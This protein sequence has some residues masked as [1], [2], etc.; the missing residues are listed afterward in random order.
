MSGT[1]TIEIPKIRIYGVGDLNRLMPFEFEGQV[2]AE[3]G[4][5]GKPLKDIHKGSIS[6]AEEATLF[7][8]YLL[9]ELDEYTPSEETRGVIK[10]LFER[11]GRGNVTDDAC[12]YDNGDKRMKKARPTDRRVRWIPHPEGFEKAD[13]V[14]K[15]II[16]ED[17]FKDILVPETGYVEMTCDGLYRPDTGTPFSTAKSRERA[18]KSLTDRGF[19]PDF[20]RKA[21]SYFYSRN[22]GE[23]TAAVVRWFGSA[24]GGRF[25]VFTDYVPDGRSPSVGSFPASRSAERSEA[26][27]EKG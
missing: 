10:H 23:G 18:E 20:A 17:G 12:D 14:W 13:G 19:S 2:A 11:M 1:P 6:L 25:F 21:V 7:E 5:Y 16:G 26:G 27:P 4:S 9:S 8:A 24:D 22:E 15:A 3:I